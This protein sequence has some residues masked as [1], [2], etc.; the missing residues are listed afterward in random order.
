MQP[1]VDRGREC[2]L[3]L[4]KCV[5]NLWKEAR[6]TRKLVSREER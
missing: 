3:H 2:K 5:E 1:C 6:K 4:L